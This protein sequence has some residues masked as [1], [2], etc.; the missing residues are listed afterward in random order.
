MTRTLCIWVAKFFKKYN[1]VSD[2]G[3]VCP[4]IQA[5][6]IFTGFVMDQNGP[7]GALQMRKHN[8]R[9]YAMEPMGNGWVF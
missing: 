8:S 2:E 6:A 3:Y 7:G 4:Q 1:L 5:L 9:R